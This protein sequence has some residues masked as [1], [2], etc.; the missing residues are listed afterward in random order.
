MERGSAS[1]RITG[2][3]L[4]NTMYWQS[5]LFIVLCATSVHAAQN[6]TD[7]EWKSAQDAYLKGDFVAAAQTFEQIIAEAPASYFAMYNLGNCYLQDGNIGKAILWYERARKVRPRDAD[8]LHNLVIANGKRENPVVEIQEFFAMRW[9]RALSG[10]LTVCLWACLSLLL[11][12]ALISILAWSIR[13]SMWGVRRWIAYALAVI[14]V[15]TVGI[16]AQRFQD[17]H[18]HD[19]AIVT[20]HEVLVSIAPDSESKLVAKIGA[21][22]KVAILDSLNNHFKIR[23]AN[24]E[25][26]WIPIQSVER[27]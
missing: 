7:E 22:E 11:F 4:N 1:E 25:Q 24:F 10:T 19:Q 23:L 3:I 15:A 2:L 20:E 6:T 18:R 26:G 16:G 17:L 14:F 13:T 12:W 5:L 21:G 9:I 8:V 27:I